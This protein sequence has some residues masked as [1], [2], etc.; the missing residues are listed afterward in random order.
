MKRA[1]LKDKMHEERSSHSRVSSLIKLAEERSSTK[2]T[3]ES[4][5]AENSRI[6]RVKT[7]ASLP[8]LKPM[9]RID[10]I[11]TIYSDCDEEEFSYK[12]RRVMSYM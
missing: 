12:P 11:K 6:N 4:S 3:K 5:V 7:E 9:N 1:M 8:A 10:R 2:T